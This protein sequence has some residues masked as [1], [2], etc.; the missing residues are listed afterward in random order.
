MILRNALPLVLLDLLAAGSAARAQSGGHD[1]AF[2]KVPFD[3]WMA[4]GDQKHFRWTVRMGGTE[5]SGHQRLLTKIEVQVDGNELVS[6][7]GHGQLVMMIQIQDKAEQVYQ[8]HGVIDLQD[9]KDDAG[10]SN[11]VYVQ[12][13]FVL[14]GDYRASM[15]IFD[16]KTGEH[17]AVQKPLHVGGLRND[18][19]PGAWKDL[20]A[21]EMLPA[22][23]SARRLV[24]SRPDRALASVCYSPRRPVRRGSSDDGILLRARSRVE[25]RHRKH[26]DSG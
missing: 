16:T 11:V 19:L 24:P 13:A 26:P 9:I 15:L 20:P 10:K 22:M 23:G 3:T 12:S 17:S 21:V 1:R 8:A 7:R 18:P 25:R 4:D 2:S 6:R 5:L 14:P